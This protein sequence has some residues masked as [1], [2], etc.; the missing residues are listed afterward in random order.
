MNNL[1]EEARM[2]REKIKDAERK[3]E[4][5]DKQ[6]ESRKA[7]ITKITNDL[8]ELKKEFNR[9]Q[10]VTKFEPPKD[11]KPAV[12]KNAEK[13]IITPKNGVSTAGRKSQGLEVIFIF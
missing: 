6:A 12:N 8:T 4:N 10:Q 1:A 3:K 5:N 13:V 2:L 9:V 7:Y 11:N